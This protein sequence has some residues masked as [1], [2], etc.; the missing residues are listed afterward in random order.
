MSLDELVGSSGPTAPSAPLSIDELEAS[1]QAVSEE[2]KTALLKAASLRASS[3]LPKPTSVVG[4]FDRQ[5]EK[6]F[7]S[8]KSIKDVHVAKTAAVAS[9]GAKR[10]VAIDAAPAPA[11]APDAAPASKPLAARLPASVGLARKPN[12][13]PSRQPISF[14]STQAFQSAI[15]RAA[16]AGKAGG[17]ENMPGEQAESVSSTRLVNNKSLKV[18]ME[19]QKALAREAMLQK[20]KLNRSAAKMARRMESA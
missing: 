4:M 2:N 16:Q 9:A 13:N 15:V 14:R 8:M 10:A 19:Q 11:P 5:H 3:K 1:V 12:L 6:L 7:S 20:S 17:D 18:A